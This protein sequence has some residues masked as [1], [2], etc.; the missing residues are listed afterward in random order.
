MISHWNLSDIKSPQISKTLLS[1]LVDLKNSVVWIVSALP[2]ISNSS[3]PCAKP[4]V[5]ILS[6]LIY[7]Y[8]YYYYIIH[9]TSF[10]AN[11]CLYIYIKYIFWKHFKRVWA[12]FF[13]HS[14]NLQVLQ[15]NTKNSLSFTCL[16]TVNCFQV[17]LRNNNNLR[18]VFVCIYL[19][20]YT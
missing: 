16:H 14:K 15:S 10:D 5:T 9:F 8:N 20:W 7:Y 11:S 3:R 6:A 4:S 2:L 19:N 17:L 12:H 1:F 18:L 13:T